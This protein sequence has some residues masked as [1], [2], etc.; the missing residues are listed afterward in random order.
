MPNQ[1]ARLFLNDTEVGRV[2]ICRREDSWGFGEFEPER[3]FSEFAPY[4]GR[5]SLLMH[6]ED[7]AERVSPDALSELRE[8]ERSI[9]GLKAK[10]LVD[11]EESGEGRAIRQLNIDGPLIEW[12]EQ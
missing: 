10:L 7:D 8:V 6:A 5:W 2:I 12:K 11:G 4:F 9:D 3:S 1:M